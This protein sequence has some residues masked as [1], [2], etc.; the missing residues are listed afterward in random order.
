[1]ARGRDQQT[2]KQ[3]YTVLPCRSQPTSSFFCVLW[4]SLDLFV[5]VTV[6]G[7][8]LI[9]Q[10]SL[11]VWP[12]WD[13]LSLRPSVN[14]AKHNYRGPGLVRE[15]QHSKSASAFPCLR[16]ATVPPDL[17]GESTLTSMTGFWVTWCAKP[18]IGSQT[19]KD[20]YLLSVT[21]SV[22][23]TAQQREWR[24]KPGACSCQKQN[25]VVSH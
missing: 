24:R 5:F 10:P 21:A 4:L 25:L 18:V 12:W 8:L 2:A 7:R 16:P 22:L 14:A 20:P 9:L 1:M 3:C 11:H 19:L 13:Q 23:L 17:C 15:L 6:V